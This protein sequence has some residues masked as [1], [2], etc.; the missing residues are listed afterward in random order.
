MQ[1]SKN[2]MFVPKKTDIY[3]EAIVLCH[4]YLPYFF[5]MCTESSQY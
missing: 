1:L 3:N 2:I 5:G 4:P